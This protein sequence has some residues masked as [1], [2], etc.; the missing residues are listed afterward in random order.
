MFATVSRRP[1]RFNQFDVGDSDVGLVRL[2]H[3][4][5]ELVALWTRPRV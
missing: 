4:V 3:D 1:C 2:H 5:V